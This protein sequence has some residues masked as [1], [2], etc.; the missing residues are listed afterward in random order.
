MGIIELK[1]AWV[2][3]VRPDQKDAPE[4]RIEDNG[5]TLLLSPEQIAEV[6][7]NKPHHSYFG[8]SIDKTLRFSVNTLTTVSGKEHYLA[9]PIEEIKR[10][11]G[12]AL[13]APVYQKTRSITRQQGNG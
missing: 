12:E 11:W 7:E 2:H 4:V 13:R 10:K 6:E 5:R 8:G 1:L 9:E 3:A